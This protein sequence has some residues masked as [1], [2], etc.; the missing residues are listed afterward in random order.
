MQQ[1]ITG[2]KD[3]E[4]RKYL[5]PVSIKRIWF[6]TTAPQSRIEYICSILPARTRNSGD[7]PLEE[8][9]V[10]NREF[11]ERHVDWEGYDFAYKIVEVRRIEMPV[12]LGDLRRDHGVEDVPKGVVYVPK[13]LWEVVDWGKQVLF[14][15]S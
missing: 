14:S 13:S 9:G 2:A 8:D 12:T 4:F 1:I 10:G 11:N 3:Y 7:L 6:Y 5:L 15:R